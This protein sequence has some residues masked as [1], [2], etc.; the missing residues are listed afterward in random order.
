MAV[1]WAKIIFSNM[2]WEKLPEELKKNS[3]VDHPHI[4]VDLASLEMLTSQKCTK[5]T[6]R[7]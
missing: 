5:A 2:L 6:S 1:A 7:S 4:E 3:K